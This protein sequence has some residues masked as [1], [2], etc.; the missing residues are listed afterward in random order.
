M[1]NQKEKCR[2]LRSRRVR[3]QDTGTIMRV[4]TLFS[5]LSAARHGL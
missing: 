2:D 3:G 5:L 1:T 4:K